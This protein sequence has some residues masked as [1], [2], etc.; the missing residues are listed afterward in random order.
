MSNRRTAPSGK[1]PGQSLKQNALTA[2][3]QHAM[4]VVDYPE[5]RKSDDKQ[6]APSPPGENTTARQDQARHS[7]TGDRTRH[8]LAG[9]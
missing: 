8:D 7:G 3:G 1:Q 4:L 5:T 9:E 6:T 2:E